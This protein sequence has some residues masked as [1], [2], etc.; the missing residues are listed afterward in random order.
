MSFSCLALFAVA[1]VLYR[2][3]RRTRHQAQW[4]IDLIPKENVGEVEPFVTHGPGSGDTAAASSGFPPGS[5]ASASTPY[6]GM[7]DG[8]QDPSSHLYAN[9]TTTSVADSRV[10]ISGK[11]D[12]PDNPPSYASLQVGS[13]DH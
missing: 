10:T 13:T 11:G 1:F 8:Y 12:L 9:L 7:N 5:S 2:R 3:Y 4:D 6:P